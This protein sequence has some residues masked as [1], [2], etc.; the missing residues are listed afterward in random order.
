MS[1]KK[2]A[3]KLH[4]EY[5]DIEQAEQKRL[6]KVLDWHCQQSQVLD[7]TK[8]SGKSTATSSD[9]RSHSERSG[10]DSSVAEPVKASS[11]NPEGDAES[12][13]IHPFSI[14]AGVE[15]GHLNRY[16]NMWPVS[17]SPCL[18]FCTLLMY[19]DFEQYEHARVRLENVSSPTC[20][21]Y[22]N[23]SHIRLR[24]TS[25]RYIASQGPLEQTTEHF[26]RLVLQEKVHV[27]VMLTL[28]QEGGRDKCSNYFQTAEYND[29]C[30]TLKEERGS[31]DAMKKSVCK[32][33][34]FFAMDEASPL[35]DS[36]PAQTTPAA[37]GDRTIPLYA[38]TPS[39]ASQSVSM[40]HHRTQTPSGRSRFHGHKRSTSSR[41]D[42]AIVRRTIEL[43]GKSDPP[44]TEPHVVR[45]IQYIKWPDFDI[46]PDPNILV[47]LISETNRAQRDLVE[48]AQE[49]PPV[50]VHCSA[51]V[52]RTGSK[53]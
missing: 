21:D 18:A 28:L 43:R 5:F 49:E 52:G 23:A 7:T 42:S 51:G 36:P 39:Q 38:S 30:V 10:I 25:K 34:G 45:H 24:G 4:K 31:I 48:L 20:G 9:P 15:K 29:I 14:S 17:T 35:T 11:E 3:E 19:I 40:Q 2:R 8:M 44:G 50:L 53:S 26:W 47:D 41:L 6:Q 33:F 1:P 27:I 46:P 32:D 16:K 22:I 37:T 12:G 13:Q